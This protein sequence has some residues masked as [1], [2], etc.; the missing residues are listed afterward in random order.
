MMTLP[1]T[2]STSRNRAKIGN[3]VHAKRIMPVSI[4]SKD[5]LPIAASTEER[6]ASYVCYLQSPSL[7]HDLNCSIS[8]QFHTRESATVLCDYYRSKPTL[9]SLTLSKE[10]PRMDYEFTLKG[11]RKIR[12]PEDIKTFF[13][14]YECDEAD[15]LILRASN[16]TLMADLLGVLLRDGGVVKRQFLATAVAKRCRFFVNMETRFKNERK[17]VKAVCDFVICIPGGKDG[18]SRLSLAT[19][20]ACAFFSPDT[21]T[22]TLLRYQIHSVKPHLDPERDSQVIKTAALWLAT[23]LHHE[24]NDTHHAPPR[25]IRSPTKQ[26]SFD[27]GFRVPFRKPNLDLVSKMRSVLDTVAVIDKRAGAAVVSQP[28]QKGQSNCTPIPRCTKAMIP[29]EQA[30]EASVSAMDFMMD[31]LII[32]QKLVLAQFAEPCCVE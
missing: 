17:F 15:E 1:F 3:S 16:Q 5:A 2:T 9:K 19:V 32:E 4:A 14:N 31:Q 6:V 8:N 13:D 11:G 28:Q 23:H 21:G 20:R 7:V 26:A 10:V 25:K 24:E 30:D 12:A 18:K 29:A 22:G 27:F